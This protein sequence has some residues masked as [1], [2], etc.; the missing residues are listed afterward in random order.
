MV[1][2]YGVRPSR[3]PSVHFRVRYEVA[4]IQAADVVRASDPKASV[5]GCQQVQNTGVGQFVSRWRLPPDEAHAVESYEAGAGSQ[6]E[7]AVRGLRQRIDCRECI[8]LFQ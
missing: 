2:R 7:I 5:P 3:E 6:P 1:L 4:V 8:S